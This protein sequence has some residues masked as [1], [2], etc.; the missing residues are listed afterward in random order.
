M[1]LVIPC[2]TWDHDDAR[3]YF[4]VR[5]RDQTTAAFVRKVTSPNTKKVAFA[6]EFP[7]I[8]A[9]I[10]QTWTFPLENVLKYACGLH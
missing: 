10:Y 4:G 1:K 6:L 3:R 5:Y 2:N 7:E 9:D 8:P